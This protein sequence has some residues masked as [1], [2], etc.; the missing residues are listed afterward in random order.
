MAGWLVLTR[1]LLLKMGASRN[2]ALLIIGLTAASPTVVFLGTNLMA[3]TLFAVLATAALLEL[4]EGR[5][6]AAGILAGLA[7]LTLTVGIPL[8]VACILTLVARRRLRGAVIFAAAAMAMAAPWF[9]WSLAHHGIS[10]NIVTGLAASEKLVVLG[11]NLLALMASPFSL[12][13]GSNNTFVI[14]L[15]VVVL[16]WSLFVRRQLVPDLFVA[17]YCL[18][19]LGLTSPPERFV[20]AILPLVLWILWRVFRLMGNREALAAMVLIGALVP[21]WADAIR[22][23]AAR[24][25]GYFQVSGPADNWREMQKMFNFI[26]TDTAP[27]SILLANMDGVFYLNTGRKT[28][29]GFTPNGFDLYYAPRPSV[30]TPDQ[31]SN[32]ILQ[33]RVNY[34]ALTPDIG[35]PESGA[36]HKS[37]EALERGGVLEPVSIPGGSREYR[38]L[39]VIR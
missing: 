37:V 28:I 20:G 23:P 29:R 8:I 2:D 16:G 34:V 26:K 6:L 19:L 22:I 39:R 35:L 32:A 38:L 11:H 25:T 24:A 17:L 9:G 21:L 14:F 13:S 1:K 5:T 30:V 33:A 27:D 10:S 3:E 4:L 36:F 31:L 7:T 15:I 12:L 18:M